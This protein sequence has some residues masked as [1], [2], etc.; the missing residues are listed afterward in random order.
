MI[1]KVMEAPSVTSFE[2]RVA[3]MLARL[4]LLQQ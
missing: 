3:V 4:P 1:R 2:I